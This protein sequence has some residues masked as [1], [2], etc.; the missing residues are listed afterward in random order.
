MEQATKLT[1]DGDSNSVVSNASSSNEFGDEVNRVSKRST[2]E[3]VYY[4]S[5]P[6]GPICG[7]IKLMRVST[8]RRKNHFRT[9]LC[10]FDQVN[11]LVVNITN[12]RN[13]E[14]VHIIV[15]QSTTQLQ[16]FEN[17]KKTKPLE[18]RNFQDS[19]EEIKVRAVIRMYFFCAHCPC[20][21]TWQGVKGLFIYACPVILGPY[22]RGVV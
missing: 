20:I 10:V 7:T 21:G 8:F 5:C 11:S 9:C 12:A 13:I 22:W 1:L 15:H 17:Q 3:A 19:L 4:F 16:L 2:C 18:H 6:Q 14:R